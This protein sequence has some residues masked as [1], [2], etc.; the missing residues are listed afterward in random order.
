MRNRIIVFGLLL[1]VIMA[2]CSSEDAISETYLFHSKTNL[3]PNTDPDPF[4]VDESYISALD[5]ILETDYSNISVTSPQQ[6]YSTNV[7]CIEY[8]IT[9]SNKGTAFYFY[10]IPVIEMLVDQEWRRLSYY[11]D[12]FFV[13]S[14]KWHLCVIFG[15]QEMNFSTRGRFYPK[16]LMEGLSSGMYRLGVFVGDT[17][18]YVEF[19]VE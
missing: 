16:Y 12:D 18:Q 11:P 10:S 2:G 8:D 17:V 3:V 9:N 15:M 6:V 5:V 4:V 13:D 19:C 7:D 14:S 1:I